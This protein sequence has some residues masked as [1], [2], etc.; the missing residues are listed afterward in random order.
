MAGLRA[1][2]QLRV[3]G[4]EGPITVVGEEPHPPYNR[5]PLSKEALSGCRDLAPTELHRTVAFRQRASIADVQWR[6][7]TRAET[8]D[9]HHRT[10]T[11]A[12]GEELDYQG[13]VVATGLRP[14][15]L[16]VPGP[17]R[18]RHVLRTLDDA[19]TLGQVLLPAARVVVVG[20]GFIGCEVAATA[21][22]LGCEVTL[23]EPLEAPMVRALGPGLGRAIRRFHEAHGVAVHCGRSMT[24]CLPAAGEPDRIG[25]VRLDDGTVLA[26]DVVVEAVGSV[27]NTEW[28]AGNGLDLTDGVRCDRWLRVEGRAD[29]VAVGDV[30]RFVNPRFTDEPRR[31]E[32][33]STPTDTA[34]QAAATLVGALRGQDVTTSFGPIPAFWSDQHELRLQSFG[35]T[36]L[37]DDFRVVAG[38]P[39]RLLDG[40][41][42]HC[43]RDGRLVGVLLVNVNARQ[44]REQ[45]EL[46]AQANPNPPA[47]TLSTPL[48]GGHLS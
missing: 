5:P 29:V 12:D 38:D 19:H 1:A 45:R 31:V 42:V 3:A 35:M 20:A 21:R 27:P 34:K 48:L 43:T 2:E 16:A 30:A 23:V 10:V 8:A 26:A 13:L 11:L 28:L 41:T 46:V 39:D 17:H 14:R 25:A 33:W 7:G 37:A 47:E 22:A 32:H 36:G 15:R 9:L 4:W 18:G 6:L 40:V 44:H 24:A